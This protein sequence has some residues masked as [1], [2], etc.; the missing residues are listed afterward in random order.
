MAMSGIKYFVFLALL[1]ASPS[2]A[3]DR[4]NVKEN[5][6]QVLRGTHTKLNYKKKKTGRNLDRESKEVNGV[7]LFL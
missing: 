2:F 7:T 5:Q 1:A 6:L 3:D 4:F